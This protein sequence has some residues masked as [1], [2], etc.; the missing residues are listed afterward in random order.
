MWIEKGMFRKFYK[1][2]GIGK[3]VSRERGRGLRVNLAVKGVI[4]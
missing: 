4:Q 1:S 2:V 3:N